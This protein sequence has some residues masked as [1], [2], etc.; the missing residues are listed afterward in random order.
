MGVDLVIRS[1]R[2]LHLTKMEQ[3]STSSSA[4]K[5]DHGPRQ[6]VPHRHRCGGVNAG[7]YNQPIIDLSSSNAVPPPSLAP[8]VNVPDQTLGSSK[9]TMSHD[10][11]RY[12][13]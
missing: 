9:E 4:K 7:A 12:T 1:H 11:Q 3:A 5:S 8:I 6:R 13:A 10:P 2:R